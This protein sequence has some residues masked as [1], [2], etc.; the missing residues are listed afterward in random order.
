VADESIARL[1]DGGETGGEAPGLVFTLEL[2]P[3]QRQALER[4]A[5]PKKEAR[6]LRLSIAD[7]KDVAAIVTP[8]SPA[9]R[10]ERER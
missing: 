5:K 6:F 2:T 3:A 10:A 4:V 1:T 7:P 8:A 9:D